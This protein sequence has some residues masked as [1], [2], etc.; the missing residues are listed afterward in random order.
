[1]GPL[2]PAEYT[3]VP[4]EEEENEWIP[5]QAI[6]ALKLRAVSPRSGDDTSIDTPLSSAVFERAGGSRW[7]ISSRLSLSPDK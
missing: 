7:G 3:V 4:E 1:M 6:H 5:Q 2:P